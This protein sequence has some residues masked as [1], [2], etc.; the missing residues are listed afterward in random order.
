[1]QAVTPQ[2]RSDVQCSGSHRTPVVRRDWLDGS[3]GWVV[4]GIHPVDLDVNTGLTIDADSQDHTDSEALRGL[5]G[6]ILSIEQSLLT[7]QSR[8]RDTCK[9]AVCVRRLTDLHSRRA[10]G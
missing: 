4:S 3:V 5:V 8:A 6:R 1:M 10:G 2:R 9:P 7:T